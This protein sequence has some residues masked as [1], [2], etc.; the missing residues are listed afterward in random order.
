MGDDGSR[1]Q[2][3]PQDE[4]G[5]DKVKGALSLI[6]DKLIYQRIKLGQDLASLA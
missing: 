6:D 3:R 4:S 2:V 5:A 1:G